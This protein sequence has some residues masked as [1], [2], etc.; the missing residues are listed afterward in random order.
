MII[1]VIRIRIRI[2]R[3]TWNTIFYLYNCYS[4]ASKETS[5]LYPHRFATDLAHVAPKYKTNHNQRGRGS[6][7]ETMN[8]VTE[9]VNILI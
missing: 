6:I 4:F 5:A 7:L 1:I 9:A 2:E 8:V 3:K